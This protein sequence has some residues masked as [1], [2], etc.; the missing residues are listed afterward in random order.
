MTKLPQIRPRKLVKFF[1]KRGFEVIR[2]K[3]SH[4]R[5]AHPDG[6]KI[7]VAVHNKPISPGTLNA[8]L[9]Q[10]QLERKKF[11]DLFKG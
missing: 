9:R 2:Q 3:G 7:T 5:L 11:I 10:A 1:R 6:R 4:L 8:I